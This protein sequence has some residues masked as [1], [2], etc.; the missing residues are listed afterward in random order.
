M[1][2]SRSVSSGIWRTRDVRSIVN[3]VLSQTVPA[4]ILGSIIVVPHPTELQPNGI[5]QVHVETS[6]DKRL[7]HTWCVGVEAIR[8]LHFPIEVVAERLAANSAG[9]PTSAV[10]TLLSQLPPV[11]EIAPTRSSM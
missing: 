6:L 7:V 9:P 2:P 10:I 5:T 1:K 11:Y 8:V 4:R 3:Q